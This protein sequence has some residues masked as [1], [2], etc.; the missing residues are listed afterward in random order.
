VRAGQVIGATDRDGGHPR[1]PHYSPADVAATVYRAVGIDT[2]TTLY[3]RQH[4]PVP[5]LP[6]GRPIPGLLA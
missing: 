4:R 2:Q 3:D 1:G 5:L 6:A